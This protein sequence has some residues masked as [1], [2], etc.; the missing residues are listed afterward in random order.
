MTHYEP[1]ATLVDHSANPISSDDSDLMIMLGLKHE[2]DYDEETAMFKQMH[3]GNEFVWDKPAKVN[4]TYI[5]RT[6]KYD[7]L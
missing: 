4:I 2:D 3:R 6:R 7:D 5:F 1:K